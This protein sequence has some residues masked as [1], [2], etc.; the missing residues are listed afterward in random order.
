V[1]PT[2]RICRACPRQVDRRRRSALI[3]QFGAGVAN[4]IDI[5]AAT[6]VGV[7]L[8]DMPRLNA[9]DVA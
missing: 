6:S 3:Q 2:R 7:W 8:A 4:I 9:V 1:V 5:A